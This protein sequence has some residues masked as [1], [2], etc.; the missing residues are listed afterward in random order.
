MGR[1]E[2]KLLI[3]S[4]PSNAVQS[5]LLRFQY[6]ILLSQLTCRSLSAITSA[7]VVKILASLDI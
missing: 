7:A 1:K 5:A 4:L 2:L 3:S 6:W